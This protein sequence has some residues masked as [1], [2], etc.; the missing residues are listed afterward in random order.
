MTTCNSNLSKDEP[1]IVLRENRKELIYCL[2][3]FVIVLQVS[4]C[5]LYHGNNKLPI[6][7]QCNAEGFKDTKGVTRSRKLK[8]DR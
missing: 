6:L 4:N 7:Y 1:N 3:E 5:Q 8:K 2:S